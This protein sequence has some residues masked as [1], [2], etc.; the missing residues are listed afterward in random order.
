MMRKDEDTGIA[1]DSIGGMRI[2][3]VRHQEKIDNK[4]GWVGEGRM[5]REKLY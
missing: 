2:R 4:H 1:Y 3:G 5:F